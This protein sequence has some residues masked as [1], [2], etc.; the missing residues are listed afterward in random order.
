MPHQVCQHKWEDFSQEQWVLD[1]IMPADDTGE[2]RPWFSGD[3]DIVVDANGTLH[4]V[5]AV[6][7]QYFGNSP[8]SVGFI[9]SD[10]A[11][12]FIIHTSTSDG[13]TWTM[14]KLSDKLSDDYEF[15]I[16]FVAPPGP[17]QTDRLQASRTADGSH[18][19][20]TW[21]RSYDGASVNQFPEIHGLGF[22]ASTGLWT[23]VR[24]LSAGTD[25]DA[26]AW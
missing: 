4:L 20:F 11:T 1:H 3:H 5:G 2:P 14:E 15:P 13:V 17:S 10:I 16:D 26:T 19:F 6:L 22:N 18:V 8:D 25:A 12:Q 7:S 9:F 23:E 21:N 24:S